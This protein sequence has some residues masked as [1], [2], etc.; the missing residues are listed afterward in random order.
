MAHKGLR[1]CRNYYIY[2]VLSQTPTRVG[3]AIRKLAG[4]QYNHAS[5]AFDRELR[6]LYSFARRQY[7]NP[8]D[9]G[10]VREHPDCFSLGRSER[11]NA[12]IY[13]IPV[14]RQQ[15]LR[16]KSRILEIRHDGDGYLYN[17][18]SVLLF[19]IMKGFETYKAYSCAEFVAHMLRTMDIELPC[20]KHECA[21]TPQEFGERG[22]SWLMLEGNLLDYF[23]S[24]PGR[25]DFFGRPGY[26]RMA[27]TSAAL[28]LALLYRKLR[29]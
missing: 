28:V 4:I 23:K 14:T 8:L 7:K 27:K 26:G 19:P 15:Y 2:V 29:F 17:L 3:G 21:Y 16:G 6:Q 24:P 22:G 1:A 11:V 18:F 25:G 12:R 5:I 20:G 10:L 9:A 13:K